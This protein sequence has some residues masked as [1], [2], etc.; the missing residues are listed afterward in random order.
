M[1]DLIKSNRTELIDRLRRFQEE[2]NLDFEYRDVYQDLRLS[3]T[4]FQWI[5]NGKDNVEKI[6]RFIFYYIYKIKD[7]SPFLNALKIPYYWIYQKISETNA[8]DKWIN[9]YKR[10]IQDI[11][12]NQDWN[13]H[14]TDYLWEIQKG[15][16]ELKRGNYLI[17]FGK[18]GFGK[19]WLA[20]D[21]CRDYSVISKMNF[22]IYWL[23][24]SKCNTLESILDKLHRLKV[25]MNVDDLDIKYNPYSGNTKN[26]IIHM[27]THLRRILD[28][29]EY[30]D[31]LIVLTDVQDENIVKAFDLNCKMLIT[32]RHMEKL[33]VIGSDRRKTIEIKEGFEQTE[34]HELF[35]KAFKETKSE[36]PEGMI[37]FIDEIHKKCSGHPFIMSLIAKTFQNSNEGES[38][39]RKRCD[40]WIKNLDEYS[41]FKNDDDY[42]KIKMPVDES[43]KFL[44][45]K[46]LE[47][48]KRMVVFSDNIEVPLDV[49]AKLWETDLQCTE[50]LVEKLHKYSLIEKQMNG[51]VSLH[52]VHY[53]YLKEEVDD[54]QQVLYHQ[55]ML[56]Q[57]NVENIFRKRTE[58]EL[59]FPNDN[60]FYFYIGYHL[61]GAK[62]IELFEMYLDFG[63]LEE[64]IRYAKLPNTLGDLTKFSEKI[65]RNNRYK[66]ELLEKIWSFLPTIEQ[67]L[68]KSRDTTLLQYALTSEGL[69]KVEAEKQAR[70]FVDRVWMDDKNHLQIENQIIELQDGSQPK[71]VRFVRPNERDDLVCLI[72]LYDNNI[73]MHDIATDYTNKP[74]L[75]RNDLPHKTIIDMQIFRNQAFLVLND[76]GKLSVYNLKW[77]TSRRPSAPTKLNTND[78]STDHHPFV[79]DNKDDTFT[80]FS[81]IEQ[82]NSYNV[83]L[84]VGTMSGNLKLYKWLPKMNKFEDNKTDIKT[85]F[86]NL[87]RI[88]HI[89]EYVM[90]LNKNGDIKFINLINSGPLGTNVQLQTLAKPVS[91]HQ[92]KCSNLGAP[93]TV[94][95]SCDKVIQITHEKSRMYPQSPFIQIQCEDIFMASDEFDENKILS[96]AVSKD[97]LYIVLGTAKGIIVIDRIEKKVVSRRNVSE[98]VISLDVY[99]YPGE[100]M[101][102]FISVFEDAGQIINLHAFMRSPDDDFSMLKHE[103]HYLVGE[104]I[105]DVKKISHNEWSLVAV[106]SK[107]YIQQ[108]NSNDHFSNPEWEFPFHFQI[109]KICCYGDNEVLVGCTNGEVHRLDNKGS[110]QLVAE[111]TGE[112]TYLENFDQAVIISTNSSY[113]ILGTMNDQSGKATKAYRYDDNTLL[114]IKKDCSIEFIDLSTKKIVARHVLLDEDR[115]CIAQ[116]YCNA[117]LAIGTVKNNNI[118][119][120]KI[121]DANAEGFEMQSIQNQLDDQISCISISPDK[122]VLA[123]GCFNGNIELFDLTQ[124]IPIARL[125]SHKR[126]IMN[127]LF[128]PWLENEGPLILLSLSESINF[129]NITH[130]QNNRSSLKRI[131]DSSKTRVSQRFKSPLKIFSAS[132]NKLETSMMNLK[133]KERNW[134]NKTG[135]NDK[136]EL[137]SCIKF[138][139]KS[140]KKVV[141]NDDFT[142]FVTI[143]NEG[144]VYNLRLINQAKQLLTIDYNGNSSKTYE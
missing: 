27:R 21:A 137:L 31:A 6:D 48:Y 105:F 111:L 63:F 103:M 33:E 107:K 118:Y 58:L 113:K 133:L 62:K 45:P 24:V 120:W 144:N 142:H 91:L 130:V 85:R 2:L 30:S 55:L 53:K 74:T 135:P 119:L 65:H 80:C 59:D 81:I 129:W 42:K 141:A 75:Y 23:N 70:K 127:L 77:N 11:P 110:H 71:I 49:L 98:Q 9:D 123:V 92:G 60:Y 124:L 54:E 84:I 61:I 19:R 10:A 67:L 25:L 102:L 96:S 43:I 57:Y 16:K 28:N 76:A 101:Y 36:L 93:I 94:C 116:S 3:K 34:S 37:G 100:K 12:D 132:E 82:P 143:D 131:D 115:T 50:L 79:M 18:L 1:T 68:F 140:A 95:V 17:L 64:K 99:R 14:R 78:L 106:D 83:D 122:N 87:F 52:Y 39:R 66:T 47:N 86:A 26:E 114:V 134:S 112:I 40:C 97:F 4:D 88:A 117:L 136:P 138:I 44:D 15:L 73:L 29:K 121:T 125:E 126:S 22:K 51:A 7:V 20:V 8:N 89:N 41:I 46:Q 108:L 139:G 38:D 69:I 128:S 109:K 56:D 13:V 35:L 72:S 5:R 90:L 32:T 104:D